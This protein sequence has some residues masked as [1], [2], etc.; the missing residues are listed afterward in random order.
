MVV[1]VQLL[2]EDSEMENAADEMKDVVA[3]DGEGD[4]WDID[5]LLLATADT[6]NF[7]EGF[8]LL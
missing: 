8:S 2:G 5:T 3:G 1:V 6:H 4:V 7:V